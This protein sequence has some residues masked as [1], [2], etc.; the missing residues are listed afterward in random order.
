M[1][2]SAPSIL[3]SLIRLGIDDRDLYLQA[4]EAVREPGLR[5]VLR[6]MAESLQPVIVDLQRE[7]VARDGR[8]AHGGTLIG[9]A[10]RLGAVLISSLA[11]DKDSAY[12]LRLEQAE[13]RLLRAFEHEAISHLAP[14]DIGMVVGRHLPR[15][16]SI[17][18]DMHSLALAARS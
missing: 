8:P 2:R 11:G 4:V 16:R 10:R 5:T 14:G 12:I 1:K 7:V 3:N 15:L 6:E 9:S 17:H 13:G 18:L